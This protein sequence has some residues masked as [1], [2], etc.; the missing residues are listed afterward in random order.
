MT[1]TDATARQ[2]LRDFAARLAEHVDD[3]AADVLTMAAQAEQTAGLVRAE[4]TGTT[5]VTQDAALA[6][7]N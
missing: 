7:R 6:V 4:V 1:N 2:I 3:P 5:T